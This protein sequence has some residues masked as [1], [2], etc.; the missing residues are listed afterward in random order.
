MWKRRY[1]IVVGADGSVLGEGPDCRRVEVRYSE[2]GIEG[3]LR[4]DAM[5]V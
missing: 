1:G 3:M 4:W 2:S 5:G